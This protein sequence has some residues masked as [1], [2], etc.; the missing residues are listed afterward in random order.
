MVADLVSSKALFSPHHQQTD[1]HHAE[2]LFDMPTLDD[3]KPPQLMASMPEVCPGGGGILVPCLF[4]R[5][6]PQ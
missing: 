6:L 5:G 1:F 4:L 2:M 3:R